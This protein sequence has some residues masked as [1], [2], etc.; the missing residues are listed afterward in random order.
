MCT[1]WPE[2]PLSC[3]PAG[4]RAVGAANSQANTPDKRLYKYPFVASEVLCADVPR[5]QD[6][7]TRSPEPLYSVLASLDAAP[8]GRMEAMR[9]TYAVKVVGALLRSRS[10]VVL[11][12]LGSRRRPD[13]VTSLLRQLAL[14]PVADL[15]VRLLEPPSPPPAPTPVDPLDGGTGGWEGLCLGG[16]DSS[17]AVGAAPGGVAVPTAALQLLARTDVLGRLV[18]VIAEQAV[19]AAGQGGAAAASDSD[20]DGSV[21]G[22][23]DGAGGGGTGGGGRGASPAVEDPE[24]RRVREATLANA[25]AT[26]LELSRELLQLRASGAAI[27]DPLNVFGRGDL[28]GRLLDAGLTAAAA[29]HS[30]ALHIAL[31]TLG[32]LLTTPAN[33]PAPAAGGEGGSPQAAEDADGSDEDLF[34]WDGTG[35][36]GGDGGGD[37]AAAGAAD[38]EAPSATPASDVADGTPADVTAASM[39]G[40]AD[41]GSDASAALLPPPPRL[42]STAAVEAVLIARL[43][44]LMALVIEDGPP[45]DAT[46]SDASAAA[47]GLP[48]PPPPPLGM[49]RLMVIELLCALFALGGEEAVAALCTADAPALLFR[50]FATHRWSSMLHTTVTDAVVALLS[51]GRPY[52][53]RALFSGGFVP[54][55]VATWAEGEAAS[56]RAG[57]SVAAAPEGEG[58]S[59]DGPAPATAEAGQP[60]EVPGA[61]GDESGATPSP[62]AANEAMEESERPAPAPAPPPSGEEAMDVYGDVAAGAGA[63][64]TAATSTS[65]GGAEPGSGVVSDSVAE[66][67]EQAVADG[68][69]AGSPSP[70]AQPPTPSTTPNAEALRAAG[71]VASFRPGFMGHLIQLFVALG[72]FIDKLAAGPSPGSGSGAEGGPADAR[73]AD[74]GLPSADVAAVRALMEGMGSVAAALRVQQ[75]ALCGDRP[76]GAGGDGTDGD[77][78]GGEEDLYEDATPL[79]DLNEVIHNLTL[80]DN[81]VRI[82]RFAAQLL[83][84]SGVNAAD[85]LAEDE[86]E[87]TPV[88]VVSGGVAQLVIDSDED[89]DSDDNSAYSTPEA[90]PDPQGDDDGAVAMDGTSATADD[91]A[92][93]GGDRDGGAATRLGFA[94]ADPTT[95]PSPPAVEGVMAPPGASL[96][97]GLGLVAPPG[98][99]LAAGVGVVPVPPPPLDAADVGAPDPPP[100]EFP[101]ALA[102]GAVVVVAGPPAAA[103]L[104][105][106]A[107]VTTPTPPSTTAAAP[108]STSPAPA[109]A[110]TPTPTPGPAV[111]GTPAGSSSSPATGT[112]P[113]ATGTPPSPPPA[114]DGSCRPRERHHGGP[115]AAAAGA[116]PQAATLSD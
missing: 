57:L 31:D 83:S 23:D 89:D 72:D 79:F 38:E 10:G 22:S 110:P 70:P 94:P 34:D 111:G 82:N 62:P 73:L 95:V 58:G 15:L 106:A 112:P 55:L 71:G 37:G 87:A 26:L 4:L 101:L 17:A 65:D 90:Y 69:S 50:R 74:A 54:W 68:G 43:P 115:A 66:A 53:H 75:K 41:L 29:G 56:G 20:G 28:C 98:A 32:R 64:G 12:H 24:D 6:A 27:P 108:T 63:E 107:A 3:A 88:G 49:T 114:A 104:P 19:P 67:D 18:S 113:P 91:G 60:P 102:A 100:A 7:M 35:A 96:V 44:A 93:G 33:V 84:Q 76:G 46:P 51:T 1:Q 45:A 78:E 48:P 86:E 42:V 81:A 61:A 103:F 39:A 30:E 16:G 2:E 59:A 52:A 40:D 109:P 85:L 80:P 13:L 99:P 77:G 47:A 14:A 25:A 21:S 11:A 116:S 9:A 105:L 97:G 92:G 36:G 5:I 8:A